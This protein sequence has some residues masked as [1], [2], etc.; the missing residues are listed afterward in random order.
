MPVT[1]LAT[2]LREA[3]LLSARFEALVTLQ[4]PVPASVLSSPHDLF[5]ASVP[6][7]LHELLCLRC[8]PCRQ[9]MA[10][11]HGCRTL[12][13]GKVYAPVPSWGHHHDSP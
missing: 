8:A 12:S 1:G 4:A 9:G 7:L 13:P 6:F 2:L 11:V 3:G 10:T 5:R